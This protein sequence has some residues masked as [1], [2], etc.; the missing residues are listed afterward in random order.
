MVVLA[1]GIA[2]CGGAGGG[3]SDDAG[4]LATRL[5]GAEA[6]DTNRDDHDCIAGAVDDAFDGDALETFVAVSALED[7]DVPSR[8]LL[9]RAALSCVSATELAG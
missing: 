7:L 5:L 4:V 1:V 2:G 6:N 9:L 3:T 8:E